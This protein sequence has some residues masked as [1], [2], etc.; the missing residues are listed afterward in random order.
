MTILPVHFGSSR[1]TNALGRVLGLHHVG[2]VAERGDVDA[3]GRVE[4]VW[5]AVLG[6]I[7]PRHLLRHEGREP[8]ATLPGD[9][10]RGV[11]RVDHVG[12]EDVG[13]IFLR[14][15][16][17]LALRAGAL[18]A[19]GDPGILRLEAARDPFGDRQVHGG[20]PDDLALF[21]RRFD[22]C[23]RDRHGLRRGRTHPRGRGRKRGRGDGS[24][25]E[26]ASGKRSALTLRSA[27]IEAVDNID[28]AYARLE[29]CGRHRKSA[30][31][32]L[33]T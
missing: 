23:R 11:R 21:L 15:A 12:H 30:I 24:L 8:L 7:E 3:R 32:D 26:V 25:D 14:Q 6:G 9:E 10:M 18:D 20:I 2:V 1:S 33:R 22:Q 17:E 4:A 29:G 19:H 5:I 28:L 16:L 27:G 31:A 13:G